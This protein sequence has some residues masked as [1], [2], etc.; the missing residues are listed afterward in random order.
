MGL[1]GEPG[2]KGVVLLPLD[3]LDLQF[4]AKCFLLSF[5]LLAQLLLGSSVDVLF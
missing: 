1:V 3:A 5:S 4:C 2:L